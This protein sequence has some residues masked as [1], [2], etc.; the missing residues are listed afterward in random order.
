[1]VVPNPNTTAAVGVGLTIGAG[2]VAKHLGWITPE[3]AERRLRAL[4]ASKDD[5]K[6]V[7][8]GLFRTSAC[9]TAAGWFQVYSGGIVIDTVA[10]RL[11]AGASVNQALWGLRSAT[12]VGT[13]VNRFVRRTAAR[14][15]LA[16]VA[17]KPHEVYVGMILRSNLTAGHF[18]TMLSRF[19]YLFLNFTTYQQTE[20]LAL[21]LRPAGSTG[22]KTVAEELACVSASTLVS[23]TVITVAECPKIMDQVRRATLVRP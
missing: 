5:A 21:S 10:T 16:G 1:M 22:P 9:A 20:K 4:R 6:A 15:K 14:Y 18:V 19:P 11:Q 2:Y 13:V 23:T 3:D 17:P 7:A 12:P 8:A